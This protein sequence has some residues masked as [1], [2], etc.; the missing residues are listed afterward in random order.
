VQVF[1]VGSNSP[2]PHVLEGNVAD[3]AF[4]FILYKFPS[5]TESGNTMAEVP[6]VQ[7]RDFMRPELDEDVRRLEWWT[8]VATLSP[9]QR[10]VTY[11][12]GAV[13]VHRGTLYRAKQQNS[14]KSPDESADTWEELAPPADDV[15]LA[16]GSPHEGLG[17]RWPPATP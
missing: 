11:E 1:G 12:E 7:F 14:G 17:V 4:P 2:N 3:A 6:A 5:V 9:D 10:A 16:A 15:R 8:D 13:V